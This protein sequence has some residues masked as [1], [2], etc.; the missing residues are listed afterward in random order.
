M[1]LQLHICHTLLFF[2]TNFIMCIVSNYFKKLLCLLFVGI[3]G[4]RKFIGYKKI[5]SLFRSFKKLTALRFSVKI[6]SRKGAEPQ[7]HN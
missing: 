7:R 2:V 6:V 5:F 4:M 1:L 3:F